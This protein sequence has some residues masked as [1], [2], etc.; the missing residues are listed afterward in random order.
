MNSFLLSTLLQDPKKLCAF[1]LHKIS[2]QQFAHLYASAFAFFANKQSLSPFYLASPYSCLKRFDCHDT[3][4][5]ERFRYASELPLILG[6]AYGIYCI[7]ANISYIVCQIIRIVLFLPF[8]RTLPVRNVID[9]SVPSLNSSCLLVSHLNSSSDL[10]AV[11]D[12]YFP[13]LASSFKSL[14]V[15]P[16]Y[17]YTN[18]PGFDSNV[19]DLL[20]SNRDVPCS[21]IP[22]EP[23][24]LIK[25]HILLRTLINDAL[26]L[27]L[28][29]PRLFLSGSPS[30]SRR[31]LLVFVGSSRHSVSN[32]WLL[33]FLQEYLSSHKYDHIVFPYEGNS[34]ES[35]LC[36]AAR[37]SSSA[38]LHAYCHTE[39]RPG[40]RFLN[41]VLSTTYSPD[42]FLISHECF[43]ANLISA[44]PSLKASFS[45]VGFTSIYR[46]LSLGSAYSYPNFVVDTGSLLFCPDGYLSS[47]LSIIEIATSYSKYSSTQCVVCLH[48]SVYDQIR[49]IIPDSPNI[50]I[51]K[52]PLCPSLLGRFKALI[53]QTSTVALAASYL[54]L[55]VIFFDSK[56]DT[57]PPLSYLLG[58]CPVA[59]SVADLGLIADDLPSKSFAPSSLISYDPQRFAVS[60]LS[61]PL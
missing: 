35:M 16:S 57:L 41:P 43:Q 61:S 50:T 23:P 21:L 14:S 10:D 34:W 42:N 53:Y 22:K 28:F 32:L 60:I 52:G 38:R 18:K 7:I 40:F 48:P 5:Y 17:I 29:W 15:Q 56:P 47:S 12:F 54:G 1:R 26:T 37:Q 33:H 51:V 59:R 31:F 11:D 24:S 36:V 39:V 46:S 30:H 45:T 13:G 44:Y 20:C 19:E 4:D 8:S 55:P 27:L 25:L 3:S 9:S 49:S 6:Y 58:P 2:D